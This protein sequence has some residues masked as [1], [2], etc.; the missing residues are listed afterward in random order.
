MILSICIPQNSIYNNI[1]AAQFF[2]E[3]HLCMPII[4]H[5]ISS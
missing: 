1:I 4:G 3:K 5:Y 2:S